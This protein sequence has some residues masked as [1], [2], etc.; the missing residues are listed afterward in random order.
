M[1]FNSHDA[2]PKVPYLTYG[3]SDPVK[4]VKI[5]KMPHIYI[6]RKMK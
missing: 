6:I 2:P 3:I 4:V 5:L 1:N